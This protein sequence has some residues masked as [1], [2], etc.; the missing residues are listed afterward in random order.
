MRPLIISYCLLRELVKTVRAGMVSSLPPFVSIACDLHFASPS[1]LCLPAV[2]VVLACLGWR[3]IPVGATLA[4]H[5]SSSPRLAP[6]SHRV[7]GRG[8]M[9]CPFSFYLLARC[10]VIVAM[11]HLCGGLFGRCCSCLPRPAAARLSSRSSRC[12]SLLI[13][14]PRCSCR[15]AGSLGIGV[16]C[17]PW[18]ASC[19]RGRCVVQLLASVQ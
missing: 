7:V 5:P 2:L 13:C 8:G 11:V 9:I 18:S 15:G 4:V 19:W 14:P 10:A 12:R 6:R 1:C 3:R 17:P 16:H